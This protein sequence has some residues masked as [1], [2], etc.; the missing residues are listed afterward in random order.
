[1]IKINQQHYLITTDV[2]TI[3][4]ILLKYNFPVNEQI[5]IVVPKMIQEHSNFTNNIL[6]FDNNLPS[7]IYLNVIIFVKI[8]ARPNHSTYIYLQVIF[9]QFQM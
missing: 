4:N 5:I 2:I 9:F 3:L 6:C 7:L 1:M 8:N